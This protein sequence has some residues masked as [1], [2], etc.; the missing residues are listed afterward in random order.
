MSVEEEEMAICPYCGLCF[1]DEEQRDF[2]VNS[3]HEEILSTL[4]KL[5]QTVE[6]KEPDKS[7]MDKAIEDKEKEI[8][9]KATLE[10]NNS[11]LRELRR[12]SNLLRRMAKDELMKTALTQSSHDTLGNRQEQFRQIELSR[13]Q[14][15]VDNDVCPSCH[16]SGFTDLDREGKVTR[17]LTSL[18]HLKEAS[19]DNS[20][21]GQCHKA[22]L[23]YYERLAS[24]HN[25]EKFY[26]AKN[27][28]ED[29]SKY[30]TDI[31]K[32]QKAKFSIERARYECPKGYVAV[33]GTDEKVYCCPEK[34]YAK[35]KLSQENL[36]AEETKEKVK[37]LT[38]L[39]ALL[40]KRDY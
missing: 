32:Y 8:L 33:K 9:S 14:H 29:S 17:R 24:P 5:S 40:R 13:I 18:E 35:N 20:Y 26:K 25:F 22:T 21:A 3:V 39:N 16:K 7:P 6:S 28:E 10:S 4:E 27:E 38:L 19:K 37:A 31:S 34:Y 36:S 12:D 2:H 30:Y 1:D 15:E 11:L 23:E